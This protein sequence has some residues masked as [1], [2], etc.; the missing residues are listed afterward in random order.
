MLLGFVTQLVH[1]D[2]TTLSS[3]GSETRSSTPVTRHALGLGRTPFLGPYT[4][5]A[6]H[7]G[8]ARSMETS[9]VTGSVLCDGWGSSGRCRSGGDLLVPVRPP[10]TRTRGQCTPGRWL[11]YAPLS[12]GESLVSP[13]TTSPRSARVSTRTNSRPSSDGKRVCQMRQHPR[14]SV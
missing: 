13:L 3:S 5:D 1:N 2:V 4:E 11:V 6:P 14:V 9:S 7:V 8:T 12:G 10:R